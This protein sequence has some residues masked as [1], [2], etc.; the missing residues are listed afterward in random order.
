[1][2]R[3]Y[4]MLSING[5]ATLLPICFGVEHPLVFLWSWT[6]WGL[7][8]Y[9]FINSVEKIYYYDLRKSSKWILQVNLFMQFTFVVVYSNL[10]RSERKTIVYAAILFGIQII[11]IITSLEK[12][13]LGNKKDVNDNKNF[14][15]VDELVACAKLYFSKPKIKCNHAEEKVLFI[16]TTTAIVWGIFGIL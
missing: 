9:E 14:P 2:T 7:I 11:K 4:I 13:N 3:K 5:L 1:M 12:D 10:L 6:I 15:T 8:Y 16:Q